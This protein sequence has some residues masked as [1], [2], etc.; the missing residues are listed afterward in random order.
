[1]PRPNTDA[2]GHGRE[3]EVSARRTSG[4]LAKALATRAKI[5]KRKTRPNPLRAS[6]RSLAEPCKG[7][8][9]RPTAIN[10]Q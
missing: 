4:I 7:G 6:K 9:S 3:Q 2:G 5:V 8:A 1:M 10:G